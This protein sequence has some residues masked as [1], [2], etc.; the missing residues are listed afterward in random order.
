MS[1]N[2]WDVVHLPEG[3]KPIGCKWV[4][5]TKL[6]VDGSIER[7]KTRLVVKGFNQKYG[8]D[9]EETFSLV[10]EMATVRSILS[11]AASRKW[12]VFQLDVNNAFLHGDLHEEVYMHLPPGIPNPDNKVCKLK[13]SIYGLKQASREWFDKLRQELKF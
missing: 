13:K 1:N 3:K 8:I 12:K 9:Y 2:T 7:F 6:K 5:K 4:F 11:L 10:V